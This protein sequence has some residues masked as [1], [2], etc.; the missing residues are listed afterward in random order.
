MQ[1]TDAKQRWLMVL[2]LCAN[3]EVLRR[4]VQERSPDDKS[5]VVLLRYFKMLGRPV[6]FDRFDW[7][8]TYIFR[9]RLEDQGPDVLTN[10]GTQV[11]E[12]F[13]EFPQPPL[14]P[15]ATAVLKRME[16]ALGEIKAFPN[17][18]ALTKSGLIA[19]GRDWK[20]RFQ[21]ERHHPAVLA[22]VVNYNLTL[23]KAFRDLFNRATLESRELVNMLAT[24]DYRGNIEHLNRLTETGARKRPEL[25]GQQPIIRGSAQV[26]DPVKALGLDEGRES[27]KL[28]FAF[29]SLISYFENPDN[30]AQNIVKLS[31]VILHLAEWETRALATDYPLNDV[32]FRAEFARSIG[33]AIG[34]HF[35]MEE[36]RDQYQRKASTE[37]LW[38]PHYDAMIWLLARGKEYVEKMNVFS[39]EVAKRGLPEKQQQVQKSAQRLSEALDK[40]GDFL[41]KAR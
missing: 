18:A 33:Q 9:R 32:S 17:F 36:E 8:L 34:F 6:D 4:G 21:E 7:I 38:K 28:R 24:A 10:I 25:T 29:R 15:D 41:K 13:P 16:M 5:L 2:D 22:A 26:Q 31:N 40:L 27:Q 20:E 23:G 39:A 37:Y 12:L 14:S 35:R 1:F 19:K 3:P 11:T 30:R